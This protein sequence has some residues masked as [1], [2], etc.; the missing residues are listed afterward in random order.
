MKTPRSNST[1]DLGVTF[2]AK[3]RRAAF[4][5]ALTLAESRIIIRGI[6]HAFEGYASRYDTKKYW[7]EIYRKSLDVFKQPLQVTQTD[8]REALWWK[9]GHLGKRRVP[10]GHQKL[11]RQIARAWKGAVADMPRNNADAFAQLD[12]AFGGTNRFITV[13]FLLHLMRPKSA[14]IIDQHN[15]RGINDLIGRVR[16]DWKYKKSPSN[17]EDVRLV[18]RFLT[19]IVKAWRDGGP[20]P[21]RSRRELDKFLMMYG[22]ALK[23]R[24]PIQ[25]Q[26][27][28]ND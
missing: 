14:P 26:S 23:S 24:K 6:A 27:A 12:R 13:S 16:I 21:P 11:V 19:N 5:Q 7:P 8:I 18:D 20:S 9:F 25:R 22:K 3:R 15:Y 17:F 4:E 1:S 2:I 28:C 10:N